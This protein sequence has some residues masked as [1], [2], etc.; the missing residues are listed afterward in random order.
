MLISIGRIFGC[1]W[2]SIYMKM[3]CGGSSQTFRKNLLSSLSGSKCKPSNPQ[4]VLNLIY[5]L[6]TFRSKAEEAASM[7]QEDRRTL[8]S[9]SSSYR[10]PVRMEAVLLPKRP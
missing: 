3:Y 7:N 1:H 4:E 6:L 8:L 2:P 9:V 10:S 5:S